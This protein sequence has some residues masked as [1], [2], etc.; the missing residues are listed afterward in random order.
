VVL[1]EIALLEPLHEVTG[2]WERPL[3]E[4]VQAGLGEINPLRIERSRVDVAKIAFVRARPRDPLAPLRRRRLV[5]RVVVV[6]GAVGV[7]GYGSLQNAIS[8]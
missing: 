7:I 6:V 5:R 1:E 8:D 4:L 2:L 3:E